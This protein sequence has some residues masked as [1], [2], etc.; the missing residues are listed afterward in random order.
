MLGI[1][2]HCEIIITVKLISVNSQNYFESHEVG[3]FKNSRIKF[4]NY[5]HYA[6]H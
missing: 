6:V 4:M 5:R 1:N 2:K 3:T